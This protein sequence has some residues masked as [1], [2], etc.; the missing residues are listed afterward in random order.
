MYQY[1]EI[2]LEKAVIIQ[3]EKLSPILDEIITTD[4]EIRRLGVNSNLLARYTSLQILYY[5]KLIEAA[6]KIGYRQALRKVKER[7]I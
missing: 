2:E 6:Y 4:S 1:L 3:Q 5:N 7:R